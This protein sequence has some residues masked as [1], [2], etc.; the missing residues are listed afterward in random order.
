MLMKI[1]IGFS[2][3]DQILHFWLARTHACS[4]EGLEPALELNRLAKQY[5]DNLIVALLVN[6]YIKG[7][8]Q[9]SVEKP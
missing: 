7:K 4:E 5:K 8:I 6:V 1:L 3:Q 2:C 9:P